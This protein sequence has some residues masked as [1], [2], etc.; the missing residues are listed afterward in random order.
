VET[1][2]D[3][4]WRLGSVVVFAAGNNEADVKFTSPQ[5]QFQPLVIAASDPAREI[6]F[7]SNFGFLDVAAPGAGR[8]DEPGVFDPISGVL[9]LKASGCNPSLC[10]AG[11][12]VAGNY[13]RL[14]GTSM[15]TPHVA[16]LAALIRSQ[17]PE[18]SNEQV[19]QVIRRSA[20]D[21]GPPGFDTT[22]GYG[23][24]DAAAALVEPVPLEAIVFTPP[25][26]QNA[27]ADTPLELDGI[28]AGPGFA[29]FEL[30]VGAG[31]SPSTFTT[32]AQSTTPVHSG[33]LATWDIRP[34]ASG[35]YT[36]ILTATTTDGRR[37]QDHSEIDIDH[38]QSP[39]PPPSVP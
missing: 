24:I 17:H 29:S 1:A 33:K 3:L 35:S 39:P 7:F 27:A 30:Q 6:A 18:Y 21:A 8:P 2:V 36:L 19:R 23:I 37:Y 26:L 34:L 28:A 16:G 13:L 11:E 14:A 22:F 31:T 38:G 4:A 10:G 20:A 12:I 15:A 32:L 9:S 25:F 5:N